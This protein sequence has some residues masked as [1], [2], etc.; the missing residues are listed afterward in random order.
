MKRRIG[1]D[2]VEFGLEG[3]RMAVDPLRLETFVGG[4]GQKVLA[5]I[6]PKDVGAGS[7]DLLGQCAIGATKVENALAAL[8]R[9]QIENIVGKLRTEASVAGITAFGGTT[10]AVLIPFV[11]AAKARSRAGS[12]SR[13]RD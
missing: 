7:G 13:H 6:G 9:Q 1:E 4:S 2:R 3:K 12:L 5:Q 10:S 11:P 8:R